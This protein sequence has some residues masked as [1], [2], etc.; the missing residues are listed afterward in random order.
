[1]SD[2]LH[3]SVIVFSILMNKIWHCTK[4]FKFQHST[5]D[6]KHYLALGKGGGELFCVH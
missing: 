2:T 5:L 6:E 1:M 4:I 3:M